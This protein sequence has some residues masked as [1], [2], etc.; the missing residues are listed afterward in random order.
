MYLYDRV[1]QSMTES[2]VA[3]AVGNVHR[4][5]GAADVAAEVRS[6]SSRYVLDNSIRDI[7][8]ELLCNRPEVIQP[9][10]GCYRIPHQAMWIEWTDPHVA[11][12]SG[13]ASQRAGMFVQTDETGRRGTMQ[14]YSQ[15]AEGRPWATQILF[16]FDFDSEISSDDALCGMQFDQGDNP[17]ELRR[18]FRHSLGRIDKGWLDYFRA[19]G[20]LKPAE[21]QM[22]LGASLPDFGMLCAFLLLLSLDCAAAQPR[23]GLDKI[24][25][26]RGRV[27]KALLLDHVEVSLRLAVVGGSGG[28]GAQGD[29]AAA[30]LH[31]VRGH[32][33][34]RAG[35]TFWRTHHL[36]GD[37]G[38]GLIASRTVKVTGG[39][40]ALQR[41]LG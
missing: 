24:N 2:A 13:A 27:G 33:V 28:A 10:D 31:Q 17:A 9:Q 30:R 5:P 40:E 3:D 19:S 4:V 37:V 38:Q 32:L 35:K 11:M 12:I 16:A 8:L 22:M 29:R 21:L 15:D 36:R 14:S 7:C 20:G 18:I 26:A 39:G 6:C 41:R 1:A 34:R 23:Q 25:R